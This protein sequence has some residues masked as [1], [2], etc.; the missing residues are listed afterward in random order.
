MLQRW[1]VVIIGLPLLLAALLLCPDWVTVIVV[2]GIAA[3]AA[4]E[5]LHTAGKKVPKCVYAFTILAAVAQEWVIYDA[6]TWQFYDSYQ[7]VGMIRILCVPL[8]LVTALFFVAVKGYG[9]PNAMPFADVATAMMGGTVFPMMYSAIF[10][11]RMDG[12]YGKMYVL[13][14]FCVAFLGDSFAMYGGMLFGKTKL[15][16]RVSP[17]KTREGAVSGL[18]GGMVGMILFRIVFFLCTEVQLHIGWCVSLGFVGAVMGQLGDLSFS[19]VKRQCSIKDYGR[20]L[21]GHGGVLDRFDS[22]IFAA[23]VTWMLVNTATLY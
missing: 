18:V 23:P 12:L 13:L 14:P 2:C 17:K 22:V 4:Y 11:L 1:L 5:L 8:A 21:P 20:L 7:S 15:A 9:T 10:L 6:H 16:P 19:C 3:A